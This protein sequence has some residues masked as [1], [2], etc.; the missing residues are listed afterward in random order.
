MALFFYLHTLVFLGADDF[1]YGT[2]WADGLDGFI[3]ENIDHYRH[4]TG[5][6]FVHLLSQTVTYLGMTTFALVNTAFI[7]LMV[8]FSTRI[9][10]EG[11]HK[12][13]KDKWRLWKQL[14]DPYCT[15]DQH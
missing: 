2:F 15:N 5:R 11:L 1:Y 4:L 7:G 13:Y 14:L 6:T 12:S 8:Y 10:T 3:K 9:S